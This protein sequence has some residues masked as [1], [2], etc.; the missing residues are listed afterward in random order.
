MAIPLLPQHKIR[1]GFDTLIEFF[2]VELEDQLNAIQKHQLYDF[3]R[4]YLDTWISGHLGS[5]LSVSNRVRR[6]N[7]SLEVSHRHLMAHISIP[8][9]SPWLFVGKY[10]LYTSF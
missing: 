8:N 7:N 9:P 3:F 10:A 6:T 4:Y 1:E 5:F 2:H